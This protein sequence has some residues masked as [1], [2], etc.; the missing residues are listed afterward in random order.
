MLRS[1]SRKLDDESYMTDV[2][3]EKAAI[4]W[5]VMPGETAPEVV[6]L[7]RAQDMDELPYTSSWGHDEDE[8]NAS[9]NEKLLMLFAHFVFLT[10]E[11]IAKPKTLHETFSVIPEYR[12]YMKSVTEI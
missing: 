12:A 1:V 11:K 2:P 7:D 8:L 9:G 6:V 3:L 10:T 4:L 5:N